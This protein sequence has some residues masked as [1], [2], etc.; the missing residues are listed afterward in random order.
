[1]LTRTLQSIYDFLMRPLLPFEA[2]LWA[3]VI[4]FAF[5][6][7]LPLIVIVRSKWLKRQGPLK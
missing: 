5:F 3:L 4:L 1:M 6:M 7:L 2:R